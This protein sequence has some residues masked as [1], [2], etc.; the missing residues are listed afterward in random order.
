MK[1]AIVLFAIMLLIATPIPACAQAYA[2][3]NNYPS[4]AQGI[5]SSANEGYGL[6][7]PGCPGCPDNPN[8]DPTVPGCY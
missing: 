7:C 1:T 8:R 6:G 3:G 4:L 2:T 5:Q